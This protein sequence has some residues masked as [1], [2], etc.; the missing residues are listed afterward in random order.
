MAKIRSRAHADYLLMNKD[1]K[2]LAFRTETDALGTR[3]TETTSY[4]SKR[5]LGWNGIEQWVDARNYAKHKKHFRNM[6]KDWQMDTPDGFLQVSHALGLNDTLWV[7][8]EASTLRWADVSLYTN[9]F[10]DVAA[11]TAFET[12]LHGL[13]LSSTSP[14]FTAEGSYPKCWRREADG[15]LLYKT[16][17]DGFSN[18]GLEPYSEFMAAR[19]ASTMQDIDSIGYDLAKF[20]GHLCST[21]QLFTS[22]STGFVTIDKLLPQTTPRTMINIL[23]FCRGLGFEREFSDMVV[24]DA[25]TFNQDRHMGNFG[26]LIDNDTFEIKAFAPLFDFNMSML[27]FATDADL[28]TDAALAGYF[29]RN[30]VGHRLGGDFVE[31]AQALMTPERRSRMP[32]TAS[33]PRHPRYNLPDRRMER[34]DE[35]FERNYDCIR[36]NREPSFSKAKAASQRPAELMDMAAGIIDT[37][38]RAQDVSDD[39]QLQ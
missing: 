25:I 21:C 37:A 26:F 22:E 16:G 9:P 31:V 32:R 8:P 17:S 1:D 10:D 27:F 5:P 15:I 18:A 33:L 7:K 3:I 39:E 24:L 13:Q 34:L 12:G 2:L 19:I 29:E 14:E 6:L 35:I 20:K 23:D 4:G 11:K 38:E 36:N 30:D 28:E